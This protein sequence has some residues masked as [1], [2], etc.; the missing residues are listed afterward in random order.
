MVDSFNNK[1][2]LYEDKK[3]NLT[4]FIASTGIF[5]TLNKKRG[6][7]VFSTQI[8]QMLPIPMPLTLPPPI[9][10]EEDFFGTDSND[11]EDVSCPDLPSFLFINEDVV[12]KETD[13]DDISE[14][15]YESNNE[16][17]NAIYSDSDGFDSD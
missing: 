15:S 6:A 9:T 14:S 3:I 2:T 17:N 16:G 10:P 8:L 5:N 12:D 4:W 7:F 13:L 1:S 11:E